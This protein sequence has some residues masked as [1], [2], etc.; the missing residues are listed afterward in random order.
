METDDLILLK[1]LKGIK[2]ITELANELN[3]SRPGI[4]KALKKLEKDNLIIL[5]QI[6]N[7]KTS[8]KIIT[9]N[10]K[11]PLTEKL[12]ETLLIKEANQ[13]QR[14]LDT[15]IDIKEISYFV[16]LFGS[17]II[18]EKRANDI[19]LLI[20]SDNF[21]EINKKLEKIQKTQI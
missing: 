10:W 1:I 11:N 8:I 12:L 19:D 5:N 6:T 15:F 4:W 3:I 14:W 2:T 16:I 20:V 13:Y 7:T 18:N 17:I 21:K 9:L